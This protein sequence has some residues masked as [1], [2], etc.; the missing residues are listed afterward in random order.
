MS[1]MH[2]KNQETFDKVYKHLLTQRKQC[3]RTF[4]GGKQEPGYYGDTSGMRCAIG[5]L[6]APHEYRNSMEGET[7]TVL[8]ENYYVEAFFGVDHRLLCHLQM[9]H[10]MRPPSDW[11]ACLVQCAEY[12]G[13]KVPETVTGFRVRVPTEVLEAREVA[14]V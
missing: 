1:I 7:I 14:N 5:C 2:E 3:F 9:I 11:E 13:L 4:P 12:F 6:I 8:R 10:D